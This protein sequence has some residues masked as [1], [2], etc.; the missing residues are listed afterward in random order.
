[1]R[2][3]SSVL[4]SMVLAWRIA[5]TNAPM[6]RMPASTI[7]DITRTSDL[8]PFFMLS[9]AFAPENEEV[10]KEDED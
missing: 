10:H 4:R 3:V 8:T 7:A 1:M 9:A 2:T 6:M 5:R